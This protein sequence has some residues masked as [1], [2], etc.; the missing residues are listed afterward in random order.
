MGF[1]KKVKSQNWMTN[2]MFAQIQAERESKS[3]DVN[4]H[5]VH[6]DKE[7]ELDQLCKE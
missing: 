4:K 5:A 7:R 2:G 6:K 1:E 3:K